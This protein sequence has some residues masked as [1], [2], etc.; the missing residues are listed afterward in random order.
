MWRII[1]ILRALSIS[2]LILLTALVRFRLL[3]VAFI[4]ATRHFELERAL[5]VLVPKGLHQFLLLLPFSELHF[6]NAREDGEAQIIGAIVNDGD[7][8]CGQI[9]LIYTLI[10]GMEQAL[11]ILF[12]FVGCI[13]LGVPDKSEALSVV[14]QLVLLTLGLDLY[15]LGVLGVDR[16]AEAPE[17]KDVLCL[18]TAHRC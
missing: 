9:L 3:P 10:I 13:D 12:V 16:V 7:G 11:P 17:V 5:V 4:I 2:I 8:G 18:V 15:L 1:A 14:G 6:M